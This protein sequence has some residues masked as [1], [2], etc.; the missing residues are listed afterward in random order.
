MGVLIQSREKSILII[1]YNQ[2]LYYPKPNPT[3]TNN[4]GLTK[5]I[6]SNMINIGFLK[7]WYIGNIFK[8]SNKITTNNVQWV[9]NITKHFDLMI[10]I[11]TLKI[12]IKA[13]FLHD[14]CNKSFSRPLPMNPIFFFFSFEGSERNWVMWRWGRCCG[15]WEVMWRQWLWNTGLVLVRLNAT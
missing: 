7:I 1:V 6:V 5:P 2:C 14:F 4:V 11:C 15:W 13:L 9:C 10:E 12:P 3:W 8:L